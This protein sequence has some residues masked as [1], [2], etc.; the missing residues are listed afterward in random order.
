[1]PIPKEREWKLHSALYS[2]QWLSSMEQVSPVL[3]ALG[4]VAPPQ[5]WGEGGIFSDAYSRESIG[6]WFRRTVDREGRTERTTLMLKRSSAPRYIATV[7]VGNWVHPHSVHLT[8]EMRHEDG[9]F[10]SLFAVTDLLASRL[11]LEFGSIDLRREAQDPETMLCRTG[12]AEHLGVYIDQ[13]PSRLWA[14]TY[15]GRRLLQLG[16]GAKAFMASRGRWRTLEGGALALD[17]VAEP[18]NAEP[19]VL[20]AAQQELMPALSKATGLFA[21]DGPY[22]CPGPKWAPPPNARWPQS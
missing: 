2:L 14:R 9:D 11:E 22:P 18:W 19:A 13:G 7:N 12:D 1:M 5:W 16:G 10:A 17:L 8:S 21:G 4:E 15:F 6:E 3:D 20:K